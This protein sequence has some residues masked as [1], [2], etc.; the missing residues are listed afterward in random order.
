MLFWKFCF[1]SNIFTIP[2]LELKKTAKVDKS[3]VSSLRT[4]PNITL[5]KYL[6]MHSEPPSIYT[7]DDSLY[8]AIDKEDIADKLR[9]L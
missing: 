3:F 9:E 8:E 7:P 5:P 1:S 2:F 4:F 6:G